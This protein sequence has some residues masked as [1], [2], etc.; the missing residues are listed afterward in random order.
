MLGFLCHPEETICTRNLDKGPSTWKHFCY[1]SLEQIS[2]WDA[3]WASSCSVGSLLF[4]S[5][6]TWGWLHLLGIC[7][8][9][10]NAAR[11][12]NGP[13]G[14]RWSPS[15]VRQWPLLYH[16]SLAQFWQ[17]WFGILLGETQWA[18]D[19]MLQVFIQHLWCCESGISDQ[20]PLPRHQNPGCDSTLLCRE[21]WEADWLD[22]GAPTSQP[23]WTHT[24]SFYEQ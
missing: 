2:R 10:E 18:Q 12:K 15:A 7:Q 24:L 11:V 9:L 8:I 6:W 13:Q 3:S 22:L 14:L 1:K 21:P 17:V 5:D 4:G 19:Y 20:K 16:H 23:P